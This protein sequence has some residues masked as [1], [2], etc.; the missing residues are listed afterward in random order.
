M[1]TTNWSTR[2]S[3]ATI[4]GWVKGTAASGTGSI[5]VTDGTTTVDPVSTVTVGAVTDGGGGNAEVLPQITGPSGA[6]V[7]DTTAGRPRV[8]YPD[9]TTP[10]AGLDVFPASTQLFSEHTPGDFA[11]AGV[12][13]E[14]GTD[15][16]GLWIS[17]KDSSTVQIYPD[18]SGGYDV[19]L[20]DR[21]GKNWKSVGAQ[22]TTP[23]EGIPHVYRLPF[24]WN[25]ANIATGV[26]IGTVKS[27]DLILGA[28]L[29]ISTAWNSTVSDLGD[30]FTGT[31]SES[32]MAATTNMQAVGA[33][34]DRRFLKDGALLY[35]QQAVMLS[36]QTLKVKVAS[37]GISLS[38]GAAT[39]F[40][41]VVRSY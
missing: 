10:T 11:D 7:F 38:A 17:E 24:A 12:D 40:V 36:D 19:E 3:E 30:I 21:G 33:G 23:L 1:K 20:K 13:L 37:V 15:Y 26:T 6:G 8:L 29:D 25:T 34:T 31:S 4:R 28:W 2:H 22:Y 32:L 39:A 41:A 9:Q 14:A 27:G 16:V 18:A 5:V 35:G